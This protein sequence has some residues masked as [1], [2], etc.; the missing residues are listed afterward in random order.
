MK[1]YLKTILFSLTCLAVS[2]FYFEMIDSGEKKN[3]NMASIV[4]AEKS[5]SVEKAVYIDRNS[6]PCIQMHYAIEK[7]AA[8]Y[9]IPLNYAYGIAYCETRYGGPFDWDY[10]QAQTSSAG[11]VGPMQIMPQYAHPYVDGKFTVN[12]LKTDIDMN[13]KASMRMLRKLYNK[14]GDWK[15]VFGAYNTGRPC[16]NDY[17]V[18]V[19][20]YKPSFKNN[21]D[22]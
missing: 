6:P 10:N 19:Y 16:I 22:I 13:V 11:A 2:L 1:V 18:R 21:Y 12:E 15:L 17:A 14:H 3:P 7:Y 4:D 20:N 5:E 8:E 9:E